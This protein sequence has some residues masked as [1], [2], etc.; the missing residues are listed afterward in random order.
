[1]IHG[2]WLMH[3]RLYYQHLWR[4][5]LEDLGASCGCYAFVAMDPLTSMA[6]VLRWIVITGKSFGIV[7]M[8]CIIMRLEVNL[9]LWL[10]FAG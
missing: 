9:K 8:L 7:L 3:R 2:T 4:W 5:I 10:F 1:M 6:L